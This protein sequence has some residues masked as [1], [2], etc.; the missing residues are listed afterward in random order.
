MEIAYIILSV[1]L[2]GSL[3]LL[4]DLPVVGGSILASGA[5]ER[6]GVAR[7]APFLLLAGILVPCLSPE[8]GE[9]LAA[10]LTMPQCG[11]GALPVGI[12]TAVSATRQVF[13]LVPQRT[14][15]LA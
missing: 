1:L 11:A 12:A 2:A 8:T 3:L 7:L 15:Y 6:N 9:P 5:G 14:L 10:G 4:L 13:L